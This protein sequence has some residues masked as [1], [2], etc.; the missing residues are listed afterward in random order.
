MWFQGREVF[1]EGWRPMMVGP[2]A[3]GEWRV[4]PASVN[5]QPALA[6]YLKR[7]GEEAFTGSW[8]GV[9]AFQDGL[10]AE[11]TT[12]QPSFFAAC[13]LPATL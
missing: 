13:G 9:F 8:L 3:W 2:A 12:F 4:L 6:A 5:R 11:I 1:V 7:P 10:I